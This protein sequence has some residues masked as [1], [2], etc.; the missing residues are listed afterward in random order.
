MWNL[1][2]VLFIKKL[3]VTECFLL[4]CS[5]FSCVS[6]HLEV[7]QTHTTAPLQ[8]I[9]EHVYSESVSNTLAMLSSL[10]FQSVAK[11]LWHFAFVNLNARRTIYENT[12]LFMLYF[13]FKT[14]IPFDVQ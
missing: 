4:F 3:H 5:S 12:D 2:G 9:W 10:R 8:C 14:I 11:A 6:K 1:D 13:F 7:F